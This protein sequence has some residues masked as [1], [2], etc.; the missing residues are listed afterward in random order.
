[1]YVLFIINMTY[2]H[3]KHTFIL[4]HLVTVFHWCGC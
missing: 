1:M 3:C 2:M 4:A